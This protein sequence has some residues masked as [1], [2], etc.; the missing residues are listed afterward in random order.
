MSSQKEKLP[1]T[2]GGAQPKVDSKSDESMAAQGVRTCQQTH[3]RPRW[4]SF[5]RQPLIGIPARGSGC[6]EVLDGDEWIQRGSLSTRCEIEGRLG[7]HEV[8][9]DVRVT[10]S[11]GRSRAVAGHD[12][13]NRACRAT[14]EEHTTAAVSIY[15]LRRTEASRMPACMS[16]ST[17]SLPPNPH[18]KARPGAPHK[19]AA[20]SMW[21]ARIIVRGGYC[22]SG[23]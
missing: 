20:R 12:A 19:G 1:T 17:P 23:S 5:S 3:P 10:S 14:Q 21:S 2:P 16:A 13:L 22:T 7:E 8:D 11:E 18:P 6:A 4:L 9:D 15:R